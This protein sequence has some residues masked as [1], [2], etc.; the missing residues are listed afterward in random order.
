MSPKIE[1]AFAS[2]HQNLKEKTGRSLEEWVAI[3]RA[4]GREKHKELVAYLQ[5][6]Y[7]LTYGYANNIALNGA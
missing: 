5:S 3:A 4:S 2:M 6:E 1:D 7:G